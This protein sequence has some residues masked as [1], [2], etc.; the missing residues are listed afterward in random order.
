MNTC[1][2]C[3]MDITPSDSN[4]SGLCVHCQEYNYYHGGTQVS[5]IDGL[6]LGLNE[7]EKVQ[8][9]TYARNAL[10]KDMVSTFVS[11]QEI[12][13]HL[14]L[15]ERIDKALNGKNYSGWDCDIHVCKK[16]AVYYNSNVD[17]FYCEEHN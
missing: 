9:M 16:E 11:D 2:Q 5:N 13:R 6:W 8:V 7:S 14:F 3:D 15:I 17:A 4:A 10:R 12:K 1:N